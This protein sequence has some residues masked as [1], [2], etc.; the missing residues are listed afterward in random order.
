MSTKNL[1]PEESDTLSDS[2]L[3]KGNTL[4]WNFKG[5]KYSTTLLEVYGEFMVSV[6]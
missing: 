6:M 3:I 2:D 5:K 1:E 4:L